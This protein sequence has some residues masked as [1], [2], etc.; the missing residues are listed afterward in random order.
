[1]KIISYN[2]NGIRAALKKGLAEWIQEED[3]DV[4]CLQ[5]IKVDKEK[6]PFEIF[7]ELGYHQEWFHAEKKG[8][9]GVATFS[10]EKA[11]HVR[12]GMGIRKYDGEGRVLRTDINGISFY[13]CYF[14]SGSS[15]EERH[16]FKL[17]YLDDFKPWMLD[18]MKNNHNI[19]VLGDY[20]IVH[21]ELDIHNPTRKDKP[22]GYTKE[23]REWMSE[24]FDGNFFDAFRHLHPDKIEF[25][26]WSYRAGARKNNK[27]WRIDYISLDQGL[28][29]SLKSS[30]H[31]N[32]A[33]HSDHCPV[34]VNLE[35]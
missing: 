30:G 27:G 6:A 14:P 25:S 10:K 12:H 28:I 17:N 15:G 22:S 21:Q 3:P 13:N 29:Q 1:M 23:E 34:F 31:I 4:I 19:V 5:E 7:E 33:M 20:N 32:N 24:W 26:W 9:S 2:I 16:N 35:M 11:S 18:E 8:Y